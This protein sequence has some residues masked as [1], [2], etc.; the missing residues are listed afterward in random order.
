ME[1]AGVVSVIVPVYRVEK[2][3]IRCVESIICQTYRNLEIILVDDGSPD[4]S[5]RICD[6]YAKRDERIVVIHQKNRGVSAARNAALRIAKGQYIGFVDG[7]DYIE[8]KMYYELVHAIEE[9]RADISCV[10]I[11]RD[12]ETTGKQRV[13]RCPG[14]LTEY[15]AEE[16]IKEI[17]YGRDVGISVWS[18][19]FRREAFANVCF[20]EGETSEEAYILPKVMCERRVVHVGK[21]MYHYMSRAD[22]LTA[23][24][25]ADATRVAWANA[26]RID[27]FVSTF[28]PALRKASEFYSANI[29]YTF[30]NNYLGQTEVSD[31]R[32]VEYAANYKKYWSSLLL[33]PHFPWKQKVKCV[34]LRVRL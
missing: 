18:K 29:L 1:E 24:Y 8:P 34:L 26:K 10:G 25:D 23:R 14:K 33:A 32:W 16:A 6:E 2:W 3:L 9:H 19:L 11:I 17:L 22:S 21:P 7:D 13:I 28:Y 15:S 20:P 31:D 4:D 27:E 5:G 12:N 30:I